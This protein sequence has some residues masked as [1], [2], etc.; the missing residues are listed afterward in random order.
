MEPAPDLVEFLHRLY[1]S[2]NLLDA[3]RVIDAFDRGSGSLLIGTDPDEWWQGFDVIAPVVRM[4]FEEFRAMGGARI[5]LDEVV[6]HKEATTGW[7]AARA[8]ITI[9]DGSPMPIRNT[10]VVHEDGAYWRI[11]HWQ[12]SFVIANE[13]SLGTSLTT[14]VDEI[15]LSVQREI[16]SIADLEGEGGV[17]IVFTDI[18]GST[19]LMES[20]GEDRW[21]DLLKWHEDNVRQQTAVFGGTVVKNQGDGFMLAFPA[22]GSAAACAVGIQRALSSGW[23]G[24]RVPVRIGMHSGSAKSEDG[25]FFGRTVVIAARVASSAAGGEI[26]V[27]ESVHEALGG[28]FPLAGVRSLALK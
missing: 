26:L 23:S 14:S 17:T 22:T 2:F 28:A 20:L 10:V 9:A 19:A 15:L 5:A 21:L 6:A 8:S 12:F 18:E 3:D 11:V 27:S 24:V 1:K 16:P 25:D 7:I 4:Q 13:S